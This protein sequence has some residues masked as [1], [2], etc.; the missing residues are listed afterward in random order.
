MDSDFDSIWQLERGAKEG[1]TSGIDE[2]PTE[3]HH[4]HQASGG[5]IK[6]TSGNGG[7][8]PVIVSESFFKILLY[9]DKKCIKKFD[10]LHLQILHHIFLHKIILVSH[11]KILANQW[12]WISKWTVYEGF[13]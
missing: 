7:C 5:P 1:L 11:K 13:F 12:K 6:L 9:D 8:C 4:H 2:S 3:D 10:R